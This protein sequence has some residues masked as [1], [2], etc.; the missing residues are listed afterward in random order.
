MTVLGQEWM[1]ATVGSLIAT[2]Q[3]LDPALPVGA[4]RVERHREMTDFALGGV[5]EV[6]VESDRTTGAPRA[7]WVVV[8]LPTVETPVELFDHVPGEWTVTRDCGCVVP[9]PVVPRR[10]VTTLAVPCPH[11]EPSRVGRALGERARQHLDDAT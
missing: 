2:L 8:G 1:V 11:Y 6:H 4:L 9:I 10:R 5:A 3:G 7:A